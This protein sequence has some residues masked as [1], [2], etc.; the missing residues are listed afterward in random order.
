MLLQYGYKLYYYIDSIL[1]SCLL[2]CCKCVIVSHFLS[3]FWVFLW[4]P[5][6]DWATHHHLFWNIEQLPKRSNPIAKPKQICSPRPT[7]RSWTLENHI[8][9]RTEKLLVPALPFAAAPHAQNIILLFPPRFTLK[10]KVWCPSLCPQSKLKK[11]CQEVYRM[12]ILGPAPAPDD[13]QSCSL[14]ANRTAMALYTIATSLEGE[15]AT[16]GLP[17]SDVSRIAMFRGTCH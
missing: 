10:N 11:A 12:V 17:A 14:A 4:G 7:F 2:W 13:V 16:I 5:H 15:A 1:Y 8:W 9:A 6:I 3:F